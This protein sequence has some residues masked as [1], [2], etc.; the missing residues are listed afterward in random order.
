MTKWIIAVGVV[1]ALLGVLLWQV[2]NPSKAA[3]P[4]KRP[5]DAGVVASRSDADVRP[6]NRPADAAVEDVD[7]STGEGPVLLSENSPQFIDQVDTIIPN[8]FRAKAS[9]CY[10]GPLDDR[11]LK[12]AYRLRI[13]NGRVSAT[14]IRVK[15]ST[16]A[17]PALERCLIAAV[18]E[19]SFTRETMPDFEEDEELFIRLRTLKKYKPVEEQIRQKERNQIIDDD[20]SVAPEDE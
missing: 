9:K 11:K 20:D 16:I 15:N 2:M 1:L 6:R 8:Q 19:A 5:G 12:L 14:N 4:S 3:R 17:D 10:T 18:R 13:I 7:D